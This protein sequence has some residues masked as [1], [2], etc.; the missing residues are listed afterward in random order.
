VNYLVTGGTGFIGSYVTCLLIREGERVI[1]Y[2]I[3]PSRDLIQKL[4]A[5]EGSD[6]VEVVRGDI[7]DLSQ[8]IRTAQ[9]YN[10]AT[11]IHMATLNN[12]ASSAN[13]GL[14]VRVNCGGTVNVLETAKILGLEKVVFAST[15]SVFGSAD[16]YEQE[17]IPNDAPHYPSGIYSACKSFNERLAQHYFSEYRVDSIGLRFPLVY[18]VGQREGS[19]ANVT[20]GLMVNPALGKPGRVIWGDDT[21]NMLYVE[22]AATAAVMA[23][24][25]ATTKTRAFNI[26]G[27]IRPIAEVVDYVKKLI[28][29]ADI[30]VLP[31]K[32]GFAWKCDSTQFREE[33]GYQPE[34]IMERGVEK[35]IEEVRKQHNWR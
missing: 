3:N 25:V 4:V 34:W 28:P 9:E 8:L 17:F 27:D 21:I 2:D 22:D 1:V 6:R 35:V 23:S 13:P 11:I 10:T 7:T 30:T 24:K 19:A 20:E 14:A 15:A 29:D 18:G 32:E 16:K 33:I 5:K 26:S 12:P 31:G